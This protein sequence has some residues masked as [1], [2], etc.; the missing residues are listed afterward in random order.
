ME[1]QDE[2]ASRTAVIRKD[3]EGHRDLLHRRDP[4]RSLVKGSSQHSSRKH[5]SP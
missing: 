3:T 1:D 5:P 2:E 4:Q